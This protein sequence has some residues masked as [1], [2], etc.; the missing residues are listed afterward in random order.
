MKLVLVTHN[1]KKGDGQGRVNYE[2]VRHALAAQHE[3]TIIGDEVSPELIEDGVHLVRVR[4]WLYRPMLAKVLDMARQANRK[5]RTARIDAIVIGNGFTITE[6]HDINI[7]H[8]V[9]SAQGRSAP[10]G[11]NAL[12]LVERR[13]RQLYT[14]IN[15]LAE[16]RA[17]A[18]AGHA[19]AVSQKIHQELRALGL[20]EEKITVIPNGVDVTEFAPGTVTRT[21][22]GLP[23]GAPVALFIGDIRTRRKNLHT[24]L[25]ALADSPQIHLLVA[26]DRR[27][28]SYPELARQYGLANRVHFL[29]FRTDIPKLMRVAD[30]FVLPAFYEPSGLVVLE[31][32][33]S[34]VPVVTSSAVGTADLVEEGCGIVLDRPDDV[35]GLAQALR[36]ILDDEAAR[37]RMSAKARRVAEAH[38]WKLMA[39][40]YLELFEKISK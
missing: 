39:R 10:G 24:L 35:E 13:Y 40:S 33:A 30:V 20:P 18:A 15:S 2:I 1:V 17:L 14:R 37:A 31:A 34:G 8:F 25:H 23:D 26:G 5:V 16:R 6:P 9:H 22:L 28:S 12:P 29:G 11:S 38:T 36:R 3:V 19:V 32:L 27:R 4:P 7:V 21:G